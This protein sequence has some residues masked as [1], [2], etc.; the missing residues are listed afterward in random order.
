VFWFVCQFLLIHLITIFICFFLD[1]K[2]KCAVYLP[3]SEPV[4]G[5]IEHLISPCPYAVILGSSDIELNVFK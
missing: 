4:E 1:F 3:L 5:E 2:L